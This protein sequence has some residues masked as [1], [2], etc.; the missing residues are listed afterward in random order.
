MDHALNLSPEHE[1]HLRVFW[2]GHKESLRKV[3]DQLD[4][5]QRKLDE[6]QIFDCFCQALASGD[7]LKVVVQ[8]SG[9]Q[10]FIYQ[11]FREV[12]ELR[13]KYSELLYA[14]MR[15]FPDETRHQTALRYINE[16]ETKNLMECAQ[17]MNDHIGGNKL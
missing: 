1:A 15:K 16:A 6:K 17:K 9:A 3:M 2:D 12:S 10:Q 13:E 14:V 7:F 8:G 5:N 4:E 11:P